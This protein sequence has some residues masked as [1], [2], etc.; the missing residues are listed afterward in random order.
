MDSLEDSLSAFLPQ[1]TSQKLKEIVVHTEQYCDNTM[2]TARCFEYDMIIIEQPH[3][4][5]N[6]GKQVFSPL[7]SQQL[8]LFSFAVLYFET[9]E[10]ACGFVLETGA[11]TG[12]SAHYTGIHTCYLFFSPESVNCSM[13]SGNDAALQAAKYLLEIT[14]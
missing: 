3:L 13:E 2:L 1:H 11:N 8:N 6:V 14:P 7:T 10:T 4:S 12:F 5:Q 9:E